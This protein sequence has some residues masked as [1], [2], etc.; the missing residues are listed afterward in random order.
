M[1]ASDDGPGRR[2]VAYRLFAA[3]FDDATLSY[4]ESDEE[5]APK[6]VVTPTGA[7]VNRLFAVGVLTEVESVNDDVLRARVV[8]PT[9]AF[10]SYAG[11]YQPDA[12]AFF[13]RTDPPAFVALTGK[14]RTFQPEDSDRVY[15]SV[16]PESVSTVDAETRD[17]WTVSA[18][19]AT[20]RRVAAM[21]DALAMDE[22]GDELAAALLD[23]GYDES[24]AA[25]IPVAL[26]HYGT[27]VAYL[28]A[29][30]EVALDALEVVAG[31]R[32][33]VR[34]L[35][36]APDDAG[37]TSLGPLPEAVRRASP[38]DA[39]ATAEP[40]AVESTA[41]ST[42]D[43]TT[44][45]AETATDE[46]ATSRPSDASADAT[47][48]DA[49]AT[50][51]SDASAADESATDESA[52]DESAAD[53]SAADASAADESAADASAADES[54]TDESAADA[55]AADESAADDTLG[56]FDAGDSE[57]AIGDFDAGDSEDDLY[58]LDEE[59]RREVEEEFDVGFE[60]GAEV[61]DPGEA[62]IDVPGPEELDEASAE[63][64]AAADADADGDAD[65]DADADAD[66]GSD[67]ADADAAADVD[68]EAAAVDAMSD[69]DDG[70]GAPHDEVV[71]AVVEE[72][73]A[74]PGAVADA[75]EDALM[76]GKCYE[77]SEDRL[78]AI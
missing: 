53:A 39:P 40:A 34:A 28:D 33:E 3:E 61:D 19:E 72:Y 15:T 55:S 27:T 11:Q 49:T 5:R 54:A 77:P 66:T 70:D 31:D 45:E 78:K 23:R 73:G 76:S 22:R 47:T 60:S 21:A 25:G 38:D 4:A 12:A 37:T 67:A 57:D 10:V 62:G 69:L 32:D 35:D 6:Y 63:A 74:D 56:E 24:L 17:R 13:E 58:E 9:G 26:D 51:E 36:V 29:V 8:D 7:R 1:S 71:A 75:I 65:G 42:A 64:G 44:T 16:R 41:A 59:E 30:R 68:L 48:A 46:P 14:G 18:A 2:E 50:D 52:T 43:T 20:L